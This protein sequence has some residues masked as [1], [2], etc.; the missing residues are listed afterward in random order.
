[1]DIRLNTSELKEKARELRAG[2]RVL[3]SGVAYTSR[4]AAHKRICEMLDRGEEPPYPLEGAA[5]YY[6]GGAGDWVLRAHHQRAHGPLRPTASRF[7][8]GVHDRQGQA[9]RRGLPGHPAQRRGVFVRNRRGGG[10]GGP[11]YYRGPGHSL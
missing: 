6:A 11:V 9:Q 7:G 1:M 10:F 8:P 5:I 2:Q 4:D 3:L